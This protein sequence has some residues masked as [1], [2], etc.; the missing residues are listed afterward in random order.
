MFVL[1]VLLHLETSTLFQFC[2][3]LVRRARYQKKEK[4]R[5]RRRR[6]RR[7]RGKGALI[8]HTRVKTTTA[9]PELKIVANMHHRCPCF[10]TDNVAFA[11][12]NTN[13]TYEAIKNLSLAALKI[14]SLATDTEKQT[15]N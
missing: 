5:R 9:R 10:F 14:A 11:K 1:D 7:R 15:K 6:R 3:K 13:E 8:L 4:K 2:H 12:E